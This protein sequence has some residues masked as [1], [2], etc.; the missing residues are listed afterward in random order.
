MRNL[1][2]LLMAM[3]VYSLVISLSFN[4]YAFSYEMKRPPFRLI[5]SNDFYS[6]IRNLFERYANT[7]FNA[8]DNIDGQEEYI[9]DSNEEIVH[10][11]KDSSKKTT[12]LRAALETSVILG[13]VSAV[14]WARD[15]SSYDY[16][17]DV[18]FDTLLKKLSGKAIRFDDNNIEAN[19]FPGHPLSGAYYYLIARNNNL[20]RTGSFLWSFATSAINEFLIEFR[21][22]AS[23]SDFLVTPVAGAIIGEAMY[24]FG[25][26]FRCTENK[27]DLLY[28]MLAAIIDPVALGHSFIWRDVPY[29]YSQSNICH[30]TPIQKD[31]SIFTGVSVSYH[32]NTNNY[33]VG[34]IF[35]FHGKL[36]LIPQ[37][38][39]E[40]DIDRFFKEPILNEIGIEAGLIDKKADNVHFLAKTVLAAYYRQ[41]IV[42][43]SAGETTGYSFFIGPASAFEHIQYNTGEFEDW[44]G[45]LHVFGPSMEFTSFYRAGYVR[46]GLDVF[47]DF[48]MVRSYAFNEYKKNHRI[49]N[50]KS[51]LMK[52]N[53]YYAYGVYV[54]PKIEV[55]YGSYRFLGEYK[56]AHYDS[57]E[58]RDRRKISNDFHL[59]DEQQSYS[60]LVGQLLNFFDAQFFK[61]HDIWIE[62]EARGIARSGFIA[63]SKV[64]HDGGNAWLLL[65]FKMML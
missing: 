49:D 34:P 55:R 30:Y 47:A 57:I 63:D 4:S 19:S 52:E 62:A 18:K 60:F 29:K 48:A 46:V 54:N 17:Y 45:A 15:N 5:D 8:K 44:I 22:V 39:Q 51:V 32:E 23:I 14:Y 64:A 59:V 38:G 10:D 61:N 16:D 65:R 7:N 27:D 37:Y 21:E 26:Y 25:I 36:Y 3:V 1:A 2:A 20:S 42:R 11:V 13:F 33:N 50:I 53:Y 28:R 56:Y 31:I 41:N 43:D 35:G 40:A 6:S 24:E 58:G 12:Y 9:L